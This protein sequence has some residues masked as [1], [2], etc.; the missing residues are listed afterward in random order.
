LSALVFIC[1]RGYLLS[2]LVE[3]SGGEASEA[4]QTAR[5]NIIIMR[6]NCIPCKKIPRIMH[7]HEKAADCAG[8]L[9]GTLV[10]PP[11]P[12]PPPPLAPPLPE[13]HAADARGLN[14]SNG[15]AF[16]LP[17]HLPPPLGVG[18]SSEPRARAASLMTLAMQIRIL[19]VV[20]WSGKGGSDNARDGGAP[21]GIR[22]R[23][24]PSGEGYGRA[25][26]DDGYFFGAGV[27][28]PE[29]R[30]WRPPWWGI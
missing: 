17:E 26:L 7:S 20:S 2:P 16:L 3:E 24:H 22:R 12:P 29:W 1:E 6:Q 18:G 10:L 23:Q 9:G 27:R 8:D 14:D 11:P 5:R 28:H 15:A 25:T 21:C 30:R 4:A 13:S 19:A